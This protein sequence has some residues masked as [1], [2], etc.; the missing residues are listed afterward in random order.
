MNL[1]Q[2]TLSNSVGLLF[3]V[4]SIGILIG[5]IPLRGFRIGGSGVLIVGL[6]FGHYGYVL[7]KVIQTI[8][9]VLFVYTVG[10]RAGPY[11]VES[12]KKS[13]GSF[14][15]LALVIV[16]LSGAMSLFM[17]HVMHLPADLVAGI[18]SGSMTSTPALAAAMETL[19]SSTPSVGYGLAYPV[20]ILG[21]V[22]LTQLLPYILGV[23]LKEEEK[24]YR[25]DF[26]QV[27]VDR[28]SF[29]ITNPNI[30]AV[31]IEETLLSANNQF[32]IARIKRGDLIFTPHSDENFQLGDIVVVVGD[33]KAMKEIALIFG[34]EVAEEI[35]ESEKAQSQWMRV[36]SQAFVGKK[37]EQM[38]ISQLW[39]VVITR[40]RRNGIEFMP[41]RMVFE[42]GDQ[43][44]ISGAPDDLDRFRK[45]IQRDVESLDETNIL[46]FS[47]GLSLAV[48]IGLIKIPLLGKLTLSFGIAGGPLVVG[49]VF[50]YFGRFGKLSNQMPR[51]ANHIVGDLGLYLF[52]AVSGC[53]AGEHFVE[54]IM[55]NGLVLILCGAAL[56]MVPMIVTAVIARFVMKMNLLVILGMI[57]GGMTSSPALAVLTS[58]T[59]SD[60]P[61]LAYTSIY[62]V[63]VL[64]TTL[65][66]QIIVM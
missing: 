46:S 11:I 10:L 64:L 57:C 31:S 38:H 13:K 24:L 22:L 40:V 20:G 47:F 27:A 32:H 17:R 41:N 42:A 23:D 55:Q 12:F 21:V 5:N 56:T 63:A 39:G 1:I 49:L 18:Y 28:K 45:I 65:M 35:P 60:I 2:E 8:G 59:K 26:K 9:V 29:Y 16:S 51:A 44:R 43:V 66:A 4:I 34:N 15:I 25:A 19:H 30:T 53:T 33:P 36:S 58:N 6:F 37:F 61:S 7:P 52:L 54:I 3:V 50:G 14:M 48:L 62:P